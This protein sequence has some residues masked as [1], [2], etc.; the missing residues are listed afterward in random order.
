MYEGLQTLSLHDA[1]L[2]RDV[3]LARAGLLPNYDSLAGT[4]RKLREALDAVRRDSATVS[5]AAAREIGPA[6]DALARAVQDKLVV[7]EYFKSDNALLRNSSAYFTHTGQM[8]SDRL[9]GGSPAP[10]AEITALSQAMLRL[11]Q[12]PDA[13]AERD[14]RR[15]LS[16]ADRLP[17]E[18]IAN[19]I[20]RAVGTPPRPTARGAGTAGLIL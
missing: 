20:D 12:S 2:T 13:S 1:E 19:G 10:A 7:V 4:E 8:V 6:V 14:A 9:R 5:G 17:S 3:L 15:D 11:L 16:V 18:A